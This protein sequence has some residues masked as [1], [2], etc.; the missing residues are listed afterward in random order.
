MDSREPWLDEDAGQILFESLDLFSEDF[1]GDPS[2]LGAANRQQ[3]PQQDREALFDEPSYSMRDFRVC[4]P[5]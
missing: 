3:P 4:K 1:M 2:E 5:G